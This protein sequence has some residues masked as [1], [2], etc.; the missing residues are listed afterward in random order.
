MWKLSGKFHFFLRFC[1]RKRS[2]TYAIHENNGVV[3][4]FCN[5]KCSTYEFALFLKNL[6]PCDK[7][8]AGGTPPPPPKTN[9]CKVSFVTLL[10]NDVCGL[11]TQIFS[12]T[13]TGN[14][15]I[16][17]L[18]MS[19]FAYACKM[20]YPLNLVLESWEYLWFY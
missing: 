15:R 16:G 7:V 9:R 2:K 8:Y 3:Q 13:G 10:T 14:G 20:R 4:D 1:T 18:Y 11:F 19:H 12:W 17:F 6:D 5:G